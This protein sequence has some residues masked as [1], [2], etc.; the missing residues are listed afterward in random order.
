MIYG[1]FAA[2]IMCFFAPWWLLIWNGLRTSVNGP[3]AVAVVV[4]LG[5]LID[6]VR[7]YVPSW[8]VPGDQIHNSYLKDIPATLWPDVF[9][10]MT[11]VGSISAAVLLLLLASRLVPAVSIWEIQ[12]MNLLSRPV[13]YLRTHGV[14][15]AKPD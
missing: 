1:F 7:L 2:F 6:R 3:A 12:Q 11:I 5:M 8:S 9:D 14:L 10:I 13:K 4:L 15:V